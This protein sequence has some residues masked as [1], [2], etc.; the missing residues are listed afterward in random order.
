[1]FTINES[2]Y[3]RDYLAFFTGYGNKQYAAR[4]IM[5]P[6]MV[7]GKFGK[8]P[9]LNSN[10]MRVLSAKTDG[11]AESME[12]QAGMSWVDYTCI[13][14]D[15]HHKVYPGDEQQLGSEAVATQ[16]AMRVCA[17]AQAIDE[18]YVLA[19]LMKT[20]TNFSTLT[21]SAYVSPTTAW[22]L[23]SADPVANVATWSA[24]VA[25]N[26]SRM[27]NAMAVTQDVHQQAAKIARESLSNGG[28]MGMP[29][30][31]QMAMFFG[32]DEYIVLTPQYVSTVEGQT[33]A[34]S[35]IWGTEN[36]WLFYRTPNAA[37]DISMME[38]CFGRTIVDTLNT[39]NDR[40]DLKDPLAKK[41]I[42]HSSYVSTPWD[43][44]CALWAHDVIG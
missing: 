43:Y 3:R 4:R 19:G 1:M 40:E 32:M 25:S 23:P 28:Y 16:L 7:R 27:P 12:V 18:E 5:P 9:A 20:S 42:V 24:I 10:H 34:L 30:E 29:T 35:N 44:K 14:W 36:V 37:L 41:F 11:R 17:E 15:Y 21:T 6:L 8:R 26:G 38:P 31:A 33:N 22:D 2:L 39:A 13:Q